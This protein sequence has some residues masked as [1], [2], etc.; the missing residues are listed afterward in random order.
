MSSSGPHRGVIPGESQYPTIWV[1]CSNCRVSSFGVTA[2][3]SPR[4]SAFISLSRSVRD[5]RLED[6]ATLLIQP[7]CYG[8]GSST[9]K[10][11]ID[12]KQKGPRMMSWSGQGLCQRLL[13]WK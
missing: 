6:G 12:Q 10:V 4:V 7:R 11:S 5:T 2:N 13:G 3:N 1:K 8:S 9:M